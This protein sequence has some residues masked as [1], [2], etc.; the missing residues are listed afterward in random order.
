[1]TN[2]TTFYQRFVSVQSQLKAPKN[3]YNS[4]GKYAYR[5]CEDI[6]EALKPLLAEN[7]LFLTI[8]DSIELV[9]ERYYVK[10]T[11]TITDGL[12]SV[13][14]SAYAR[15]EQDKKGMD[16]AQLT[17]ATSSYARKYALNGLL[18][19]DDTKD[20]DSTNTHDKAPAK[21]VSKP[22]PTLSNPPSQMVKEASENVQKQCVLAYNG[23][24]NAVV[25]FDPALISKSEYD[26]VRHLL[27]NKIVKKSSVK[28]LTEDEAKLFIKKMNDAKANMT[29]NAKAVVAWLMEQI[30]EAQAPSLPPTAEELSAVFND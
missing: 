9:G 19:I 7:H 5:S 21:P 2:T 11:A 15:E 3:Q 18:A 16:S 20:S 22:A 6:V 26:A 27:M 25:E 4:F 23:F 17:G 28:E 30:A 10:A 24:L 29:S 13:S 12:E 8:Q 1:M 14:S